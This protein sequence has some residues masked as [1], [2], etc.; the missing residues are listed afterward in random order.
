M[1]A[2]GRK[3]GGAGGGWSAVDDAAGDA[4]AAHC[5]SYQT[6]L[7]MMPRVLYHNNNVYDIN[8]FHL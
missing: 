2:Q 5:G 6:L 7:M 3:R 4:R 8:T 1:F